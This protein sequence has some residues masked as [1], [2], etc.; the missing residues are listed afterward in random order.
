MGDGV[1]D[2]A[3]AEAIAGGKRYS[4]I[5]D[6][7]HETT[8]PDYAGYFE[9]D[10]GPMVPESERARHYNDVGCVQFVLLWVL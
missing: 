3:N 4:K 10:P 1:E 7:S 5:A 9:T 2:I 8:P 6:K